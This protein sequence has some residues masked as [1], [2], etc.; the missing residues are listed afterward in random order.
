MRVLDFDG[1]K[2]KFF[3]RLEIVAKMI[4]FRSFRATMTTVDT[5]YVPSSKFSTNRLG[6]MWFNYVVI[7]F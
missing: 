1:R 2:F 7:F 4:Y 6:H 3:A 5:G